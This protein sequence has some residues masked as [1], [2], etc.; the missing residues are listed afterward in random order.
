MNCN[1]L[2]LA[3]FS[4]D[5]RDAVRESGSMSFGDSEPAMEE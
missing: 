1:P 4:R 3:F 2:E 5:V